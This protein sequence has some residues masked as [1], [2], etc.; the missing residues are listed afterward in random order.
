M[1]CETLMPQMQCLLPATLE[2]ISTSPDSDLK[3]TCCRLRSASQTASK[4][5]IARSLGHSGIRVQRPIKPYDTSTE[6]DVLTS[7]LLP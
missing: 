3:A 6:Q 4:S 5:Y 7:Y 2:Q 1:P